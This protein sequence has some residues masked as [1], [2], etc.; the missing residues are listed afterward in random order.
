MA[1]R[2][3]LFAALAAGAAATTGADLLARTMIGNQSPGTALVEHLHWAAVQFDGTLLLLAPFVVVALICVGVDSGGQ[4]S[5]VVTIFALAMLVLL[6]FYLDGHLDA[7][8]AALR[9]RWTAATLS[10]GLLPFFVGV[11]V[12]LAAAVAAAIVAVSGRGRSGTDAG[13]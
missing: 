4:R 7:Q 5:S 9:E 8:E 6:Y 2:Y 1:L 10:I 11:P 3:Y 13:R 12:M